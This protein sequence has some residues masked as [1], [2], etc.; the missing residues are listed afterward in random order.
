MVRRYSSRSNNERRLWDIP[1]IL[2]PYT[3]DVGYSLELPPRPNARFPLLDL[4]ERSAGQSINK[5]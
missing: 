4:V 2:T 3:R 5:V 1:S